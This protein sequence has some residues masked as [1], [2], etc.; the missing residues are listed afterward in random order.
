MPRVVFLQDYLDRKNAIHNSQV[1]RAAQELMYQA[2]ELLSQLDEPE[3]KI[4]WLLED[5]A[6]IL[7]EQA[8]RT[9]SSFNNS[10]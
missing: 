10:I 7:S 8:K 5:C 1:K 9:A 2:A 4:G 6:D 3:K